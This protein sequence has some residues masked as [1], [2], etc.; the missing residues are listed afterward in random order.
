VPSKRPNGKSLLLAVAIAQIT[1]CAADRP[2]KTFRWTKDG[3]TLQDYMRDRDAC[4][5]QSRRRVAGPYVNAFGEL[6]TTRE[7]V[8]EAMFTDCL[9]AR[10]YKP[11]V[12]GALVAPPG[13]EISMVR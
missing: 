7:V 12:N 10:R 6:K 8:S 5:Q 3:A 2:A 9:I 4:L 13:T 1:A 11:D